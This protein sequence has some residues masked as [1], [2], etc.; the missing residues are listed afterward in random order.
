LL[1]DLGREPTA[2]EVATAMDLTPARLAAVKQY[3]R[4]PVSLDETVGDGGDSEF[5]DF[6]EDTEA[7]VAVEV[8]AFSLLQ[9]QL[10]DV[11]QTLDAREAGVIRLRFGLADGRPRTL[12][13]IGLVYGVTRERI[14][15]IEAKTMCKLRHPSRS[16]VLRDYLD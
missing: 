8:V 1:Q 12:D 9:D 13:E 15:Q 4:A 14:R 6:I 16:D 3:A 2:V 11:L 5:G 7:A 10:Q